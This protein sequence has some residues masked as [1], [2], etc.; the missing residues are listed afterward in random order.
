MR[1]VFEAAEDG[2]R[3]L[4]QRSFVPTHLGERGREVGQG[5][6]RPFECVAHVARSLL[7]CGA[8]HLFGVSSRVGE[9]DRDLK[10]PG[11]NSDLGSCRDVAGSG[12]LIGGGEVAIAVV[13]IDLQVRAAVVADGGS[14][15]RTDDADP[16][17]LLAQEKSGR[18]SVQDL[19]EIALAARLPVRRGL[20][21][22]AHVG[23]LGRESGRDEQRVFVRVG[24]EL[25]GQSVFV[26][27]A[28]DRERWDARREPGDAVWPSPES[29][30]GGAPAA[31]AKNRSSCRATRSMVGKKTSLR[32]PSASVYQ[33]LL[34]GPGA[35]PNAILRP[36]PHIGGAP[37]PP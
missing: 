7:Q 34:L 37:G 36:G 18:M 30:T 12:A 15:E 13:E 8:G 14:A 32:A 5:P 22:E 17:V 9:T 25:L 3:S 33:S 21:V 16:D 11:A 20:H 24:E 4:G 31:E 23:E 6:P 19:S 2:Q 29:S 1:L 27:S 26:V 35:A 28:V 10:R